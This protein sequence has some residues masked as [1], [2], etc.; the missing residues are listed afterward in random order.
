MVLKIPIS[1]KL[2]WLPCSNTLT[3]IQHGLE[4]SWLVESGVLG[5]GKIQIFLQD[6]VWEPVF[7]G[8]G[9]VCTT[10]HSTPL[11]IMTSYSLNMWHQPLCFFLDFDSREA[12]WN[13]W[14][15]QSDHEFGT[16]ISIDNVESTEKNSYGNGLLQ[17]QI[18]FAF[19]LEVV[20]IL[21]QQQWNCGTSETQVPLYILYDF[22]LKVLF[23]ELLDNLRFQ[24]SSCWTAFE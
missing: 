17:F 10:S 20:L 12:P 9:M 19:F 23:A 21:L 3:S 18:I 11:I 8:C 14:K 1:C 22:N 15:I 2:N 13:V 6:Q 7:Y 24:F 4:N 5:T 16:L